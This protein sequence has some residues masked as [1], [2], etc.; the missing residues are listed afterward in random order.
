MDLSIIIPVHNSELFLLDCVKSVVR[1]SST[2]TKEIILVEN[3]SNDNSLKLCYEIQQNYSNICPI[4]VFISDIPNVGSARNIGIENANG[5]YIHFIDSDDQISKEFYESIENLLLKDYDVVITGVIDYYENKKSFSENKSKE[6]LIISSEEEMGM[7]LKSIC[8]DNKI[9]ALNVV[10]NRFIK[11]NVLVKN[12]IR[13]RE[14]ISLGEDFVFNCEILAK[15]NNIFISNK[16]FYIYFHRLGESLVTKFHNDVLHRRPIVFD[17]YVMLY[18]KY[19]VFESCSDKIEL[20]EGKQIFGT[21]YCVL[22]KTQSLT[23]KMKKSYIKE[24]CE[25]DH[26]KYGLKYLKRG[27]IYHQLCLLLIKF[28]MY[29]LLR[30]LLRVKL[31]LQSTTT[32][33]GFIE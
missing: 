6:N 17:R 8:N 7:F 16:S 18:K 21:L 23:N 9:W 24:I 29:Y 1:Q 20:I 22:N 25:S 14:D 31:V 13:F 15:T 4:R 32:A 3:C 19:H 10:W 26:F 5:K 33:Q 30:C 27:N 2:L 11:K 28:K 12:D